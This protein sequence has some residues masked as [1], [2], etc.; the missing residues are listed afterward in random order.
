MKKLMI[1]GTSKQVSAKTFYFPEKRRPETSTVDF[2][3]T[4][5]VTVV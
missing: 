2:V 3:E 4:K 1:F 5:L